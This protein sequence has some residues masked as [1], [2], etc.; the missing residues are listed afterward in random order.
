M[1]TY[2]WLLNLRHSIWHDIA[3]EHTPEITCTAITKLHGE[4]IFEYDEGINAFGEMIRLYE[5]IY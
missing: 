1:F 4:D 5:G 2:L 3:E